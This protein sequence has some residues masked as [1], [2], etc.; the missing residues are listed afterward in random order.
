ML[1]ELFESVTKL[2]QEAV[3]AKNAVAIVPIPG[4]PPNKV[5]LTGASGEIETMDVAPPA[6]NHAL[7]SV[8]EI[9]PFVSYAINRL[10]RKPS[11]WITG[12]DIEILINDEQGQWITDRATMSLDYSPQFRLLDAW[13]TVPESFD[14]R[15]FLR[16]LR[17]YFSES[18]SNLPALLKTLRTLQFENGMAIVSTQDTKKQS[19]GKEI[20]G[21]V[22][23]GDASELP[24]TL[25]IAC[26]V[27]TDQ[28]IQAMVS[29]ECLLDI[30]PS[31][32]FRLIPL[33][34]SCLKAVDL[35]LNTIRSQFTSEVP[36][37]VPVF[38]GAP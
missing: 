17:R 9:Q 25:K 31:S 11:I 34:G 6:R 30:T 1:K 28:N 27:F 33:A 36:A 35:T 15:D 18:I 32:E 23:G 21:A 4:M 2:S 3:A 8:S 19:L 5:A 37:D 22:K 26:K 20:T 10:N 24:E 29:I 16:T 12:S 14:H 38:F 13:E 7:R